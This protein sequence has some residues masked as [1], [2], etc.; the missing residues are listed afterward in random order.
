[1][2]RLTIGELATRFAFARAFEEFSPVGGMRLLVVEIPAALERSHAL[3]A[4]VLARL[5]R[6]LRRLA[7]PTV[8]LAGV[9]WPLQLQGFVDSCDLRVDSE[10]ELESL[11]A[12]VEGRPLAALALVQLLRLGETLEL[13]QALI[14]ESFVY[15]TLQSG[16]EFALWLSRRRDSATAVAD[17][18]AVEIERRGDTLVLTLNRPSRHNAYS[19]EMRDGLVEGL[20][21]ALADSAIDHVVLRANG[22]SFCSGGDLAEFAT[23][24]DPATAHALRSTRSAASLLA[25]CAG[26]VCVELHGACIG[27]GIEL[28]AFAQRVVASADA[29]FELPEVSMGLVPGAGGSVSIARRIGRQRT[30]YMALSGLRVDAHTALEWGLVDEIAERGE[31]SHA[32]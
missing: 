11:R 8:A 5:G 1:V 27:A 26:R 10:E 20:E 23:T 29:F 19:A 12:A 24:P 14:A 16:P 31:P 7:C 2:C 4:E 17:G 25:E 18:P 22:P 21:L 9:A 3:G 32:V 30:A 28:A 6:C 15:S 13:Q